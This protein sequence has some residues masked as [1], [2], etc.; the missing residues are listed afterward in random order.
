MSALGLAWPAPADENDLGGGV[1]IVHSP[2]DLA[3]TVEPAAVW[4]DLYWDEYAI[5]ECEEQNPHI[6]TAGP[7]VWYVIS[8]WTEEKRWCGTEFGF[9]AY[10]PGIIAFT[11]WGP[12]GP[13]PLYELSTDGWPGPGEGTAVVTS[14]G[15][16]NG[17][18]V[19]VYCFTGYAYTSGLIPLGLDPVQDFAGWGTCYP[20]WPE[21]FDATCLAALGV[22]TDG[23]MCCPEEPT[24]AARHTWGQIKGIYR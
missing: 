2:P 19:P 12:C 24:P 14:G 5:D 6:S 16:W 20:P 10:D 7:V 21:I 17:N 18:F 8:A 9:A 22:L 11:D 23:V 15:E 13:A 4:C 3:Y 1:F